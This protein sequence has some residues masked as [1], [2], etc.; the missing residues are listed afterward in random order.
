MLP[1]TAPDANRGT[2]HLPYASLLK[3]PAYLR[4]EIHLAQRRPDAGA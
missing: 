2:F 1:D 4:G 3:L